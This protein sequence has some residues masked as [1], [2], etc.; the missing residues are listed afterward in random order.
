MGEGAVEESVEA[1]R[2]RY[3][4]AVCDVSRLLVEMACH[5]CTL[6]KRRMTRTCTIEHA[7]S[8]ASKYTCL[9]V[10]QAKYMTNISKAPTHLP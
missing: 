4:V 1:L 10:R 8:I 2:V 6:V 5:V 3:L 7:D 9:Y